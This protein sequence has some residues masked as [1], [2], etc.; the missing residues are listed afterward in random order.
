MVLFDNIVLITEWYH[1]TKGPMTISDA[2]HST[3]LKDA[4]LKAG[5]ELGFKVMGEFTI[6]F[7]SVQF[8]HSRSETRTPKVRPALPLS[9]SR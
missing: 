7:R 9:S 6:N 4:F 5:A 8:V 3:G 1:G 2:R